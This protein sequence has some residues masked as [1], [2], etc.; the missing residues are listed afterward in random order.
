MFASSPAL[1]YWPKSIAQF[2]FHRSSRPSSAST[3]K[4]LQLR[5]LLCPDS[6][7]GI[8]NVYFAVPDCPIGN[9]PGVLAGVKVKRLSTGGQ[10]FTRLGNK[11]LT[12]QSGGA[13]VHERLKGFNPEEAQE[14]LLVKEFNNKMGSPAIVYKSWE[15][16]TLYVGSDFT[17]ALLPGFWILTMSPLNLRIGPA[18]PPHLWDPNTSILQPQCNPLASDTRKYSKSRG[19]LE[20]FFCSPLQVSLFVQA[21]LMKELS[22]C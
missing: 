1:V 4:E 15:L 7:I 13:S 16:G 2:R 11:L 8:E 18:Y 17:G 21:V 3:N 20:L 9:L 12:V 6:D 5:V 10:H 19:L 22:S 14:K